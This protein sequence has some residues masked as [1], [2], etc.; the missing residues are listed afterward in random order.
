MRV[1]RLA[2]GFLAAVILLLAPPASAQLVW[3]IPGIVNAG[4]LNNTR[5]VSDVTMTNPGTTATQ[6][7]ISFI[8]SSTSNAK[9]VTLNA[10]E[11]L[12]YRNVVELLFGT[13]GAGA[14]SISSDQPL[15]L[16]ARTYNTASS[17]TYGVALP[18]YEADRLLTAGEV[19]DSLWV[20]QDASGSSGYR[21][22]IAVVF[23]DDAG[24][25]ATVTVFDADGNERGQKDYALDSAG[26][27]QFSVGSFAGAV[28]VGRARIHV[29]RGRA[30]GY[31][32]VVD[33]VTGDSSLFTFEDLPGGR[34]DVLINGVAR[35]NGR[36]GTFFRTD[37][38]FYNPTDVDVT[39]TVSFH[40]GGN[41]NP[42]PVT[43]PFTLQGGKIR[44]VV[45]V[46]NSLLGLPVGSSG[47]LRFSSDVP[48]AILCRTSNVDPTG[49]SPGTFGAQQKPV[50]I[51]SFLTS[52]DAG[53]SITGIRQDASYRTNVGFA[54]GGDGA[55]YSM[56]LMTAGG[57]SVATATGSLG[58]WGW[59]QPNV[60]H[61]Q[62]QGHGGQPRRLRLLH[63]Q[64]LGRS[65]RDADRRAAGR[66]PL[67][68]DDRT[69]GRVH[70]VE[71]RKAHAADPG[72]RR[73]ADHGVLLPVDDE[74]RPAGNRARLPGHSLGDHVLTTRVPHACVWTR[75]NRRIE[76]RGADHRPTLRSGLDHPRRRDGGPGSPHPDRPPERDR[77]RRACPEKQSRRGRIDRARR[78]QELGIRAVGQKGR[79][80]EGSAPLQRLLGR[81]WGVVEQQRGG[82]RDGNP[83]E[84]TL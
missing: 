10:G 72:G 24:G 33:N 77:S 61:P 1:G 62:D 44:D 20:S 83:L 36:N 15:L 42:S 68:R 80:G 22:N 75:R 38:R 66:D 41:S 27:Q 79:G 3:T 71:R 43:A 21:T 48:V 49:G 2:S 25:G 78:G 63:R 57:A 19:G 60:R 67:Q 74:R 81:G 76:R 64:R 45:D 51:L 46:L 55:R 17:G 50:P 32:V 53:A 54:A 29:T 9:S 28:S 5:F 7:T 84:V 52:A 11:T 73:G 82:P 69:R 37:G 26:L 58:G 4:G 18:V 14:L 12:A 23:P 13:S 16:R 30:A 35:A 56:T 40:A 65:G 47:A 39:V 6:V 31:S 59:T 8:P 70:P 34:Q